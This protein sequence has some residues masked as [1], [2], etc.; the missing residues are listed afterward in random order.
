MCGQRMTSA[1]VVNNVSQT[2]TSTPS[3]LQVND[4]PAPLVAAAML[5]SKQG[6]FGLIWADD[7]LIVTARYGA[8]ADF[9]EIGEPVTN[10]VPPFVGLEPDILALKSNRGA[11]LDLPIVSIVR[12]PDAAPKLNFTALW[13]DEEKCYLV[14]ISRAGAQTNVEVELSRQIRARLIAE[15]EVTHKSK[16]LTKANAE[17]ARANQ[18]L[19]EFASII[20]HDLKGPMRALR[21]MAEDLSN[22]ESLQAS[23]EAL[24][25]LS[26]MRAQSQRMSE[27]LTSLLE[28][29]SAG[30]KEEIVE[31][32]DTAALVESIVRSTPRPDE[33]DIYSTGVWPS[34]ETLRAP[35]DLVLRNLVEN[36]IKHHDRPAGVIQLR[37]ENAG[38]WLR[39]EIEDDGPG[40]DQHHHAS[41]F[42]P[43]RRLSPSENREG[44][45]MGLAFVKRWVEASG[46][47]IGLISDAPSK[48]GTIF[49]FDWPKMGDC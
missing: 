18:D 27:M 4:R 30:R 2:I 5:L 46:G 42:L 32:V 39:F 36:A 28:Y 48:R 24:A 16:A 31:L 23:P 43:F 9:V 21:Y 33:I 12:G 20:S 49:W 35:L 19:E 6:L 29:S 41:V 34:I 17:L 45:G 1:G 11:S 7:Q 22:S 14:L 3:K 10:S 38:D 37:C 8:L 40:I 47:R 26:K 25:Q 44:Q 13:S 15:A